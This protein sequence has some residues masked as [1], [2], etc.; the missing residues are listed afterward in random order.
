MTRRCGGC[1][2]CCYGL[3]IQE[4]NK[5]TFAQCPHQCAAGCSV[6]T[7]RPGSCRDYQCLWLQGHLGEQDRP[8]KLGV[9]FSVTVHPDLGKVPMLIE[10]RDGAFDQPKVRAAVRRMVLDRPVVLS[11]RRGGKVIQTAQGQRQVPGAKVP[12]TVGGTA[13]AAC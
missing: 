12:I 4:L 11:S 3:H 6:Y 8:D 7:D 2:A 9:L 10:V 1:T 13:V 5:P